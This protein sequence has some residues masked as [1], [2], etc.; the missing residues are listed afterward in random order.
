MKR[1][2]VDLRPVDIFHDGQWLYNDA[3]YTLCR[4][5]ENGFLRV[6]RG[7]AMRVYHIYCLK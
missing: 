3:T 7:S 1:P 2:E 6:H 5:E 4:E